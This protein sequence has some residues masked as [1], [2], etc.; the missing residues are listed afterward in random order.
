[1][2]Y[3]LSIDQGT[4]STTSF[5]YD[6]EGR[7]VARS[8][9]EFSQKYPKPGWV[10]H[11]AMEIWQTVVE[12]V[13]DVCARYPSGIAAVGITNQRETT[14]VWDKKTGEPVCNAIVWQCRRTAD[15]CNSL[16]SHEDIIT[17]KTGLPLDAYFSGTKL[18]YILD[19]TN[20]RSNL[21]FGTIDTWLVHKLTGGTVHATD[22]T[23]ASR[24]MLCNILTM[25]W[26]DELCSILGVP[27]EMLPEIR[28]SSGY[29]GDVTTI[30]AIR[31]VPVCGVA[32]DQQA[33]LFGQNCIAPGQVKNTYGT[34]CF[35]M[36]NTGAE[37]IRSK[38][39]LLS[40]LAADAK[41]NP[42]YALEG[43]IFVAGAAVQW[44]RDE[45]GIIQHA[46]E[47]ESMARA[48]NDNGGVYLVPAF[49]GLG[50]PHW[51]MD[52]RGTLVGLTRGANRNHLAR[53]VLESMAYQSLDVIRAM[54]AETGTC[55]NELAVDGGA[56]AN[57][58]LMQ[59]QA[60]MLGIPVRRPS[61]VESTSLGAAFLSG[62]Q[63]GFWT[64][65]EDIAALKKND[66]V[67]TPTMDDVCRGECLA[68]WKKALRQART[69]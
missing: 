27:R 21:V 62:L 41:G 55:V 56:A 38:N 2:K 33:A 32:G 59:F 46:S 36:L 65:P 14:V 49:V 26:D 57:S 51:D 25:D 63:C 37:C 30:D 68:G 44:L 31:G 12:T 3:I 24:T 6:R 53:A 64:G 19:H 23:N 52:A 66:T 16:K 8:S 5:L 17:G 47:T 10:E 45:L 1:M 18:R 54:E 15:L 48:L 60:D 4:T 22:Y 58:W 7:I 13:N 34:G 11:D 39:G 29:Y 35:A 20:E 43:S 67:F 61:V 50:T 42:C 9:K 69:K 28:K 40:T